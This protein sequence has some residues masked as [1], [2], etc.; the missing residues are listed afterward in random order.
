MSGNVENVIVEESGT[1]EEKP[2]AVK[3]QRKITLL[4]GVA[5]IVG[6][7]LFIIFNLWNF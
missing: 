6:E 5:L 3:L 4:N 2:G 7:F 1:N